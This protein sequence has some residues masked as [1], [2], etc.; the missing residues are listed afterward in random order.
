M[1]SLENRRLQGDLRATF[2]Y[3]KGD[4][5]KDGDGLFSRVCDKGKWFQTKEGRF[6]LDKEEVLYN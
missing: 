3:A 5:K 1:F 4:K 6:R 2:Q